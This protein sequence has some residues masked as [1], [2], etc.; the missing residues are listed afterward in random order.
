MEFLMEIKGLDLLMEYFIKS[1]LILTFALILLCLSRKKSSALKHFIL[2]LA[3]ISMLIIPLIS[4]LA[5]GWETKLLPSWEIGGRSL[6]L[7]LDR[8]NTNDT[9]I[10]GR[11]S[12][13]VS[14]QNNAYSPV[15]NEAGSFQ[16]KSLVSIL[17]ANQKLLS[18]G[19]AAI[20]CIGILFLLTRILLGLYGAYRLTRQGEKICYSNWRQLLQKLLQTIPI[21]RKISLL[22]HP[23]ILAPLTWG[24]RKPVVIFPAE[25]RGWTKCQCSSALFHE[26]SHIKRGDFLIKMIARISCALFWF[27]PLSWF[28]FKMMKQEQEK[29]CDELVLKAG[30]KPS[31][32][33]ANLLSLKNA[34]QTG[35][36]PPT[37]VLGAVGKSQ[38]NDRLIAIL[39]KQF[40]PKEIKMKTK[41]LLSLTVILVI[42]IIGFARPSPTEAYTKKHLS[43]S[44][45]PV[46]NNLA[47][48]PADDQEKQE[49]KKTT[50]TATETEI[51]KKI[52]ETQ[53]KKKEDK[54][55]IKKG[56][57][58]DIEVHIIQGDKI[59]K[60]GLEGKQITLIGQDGEKKV[61]TISMDKGDL[62]IADDKEGHWTLKADK[63]ELLHGDEVK[64]ITLK[65]GTAL[66]VAG[67]DAVKLDKGKFKVITKAGEHKTGSFY[68]HSGKGDKKIIYAT[69]H[70]KIYSTAHLDTHHEK[71]KEKIKKIREKLE[72]IKKAEDPHAQAETRGETITELEEMLKELEEI[73]QQKT[74]VISYSIHTEPKTKKEEN[75]EHIRF[76]KLDADNVV[77]NFAKEDKII[78]LKAEEDGI[79]VIFKSESDADQKARHEDLL[80]K[81][82]EKLP[83]HYNIE[84]ITDEDDDVFIIKIVNT[85]KDKEQ[86]EDI[87]QLL[88]EIIGEIKDIKAKDKK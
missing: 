52:S 50:K 47:F 63:L 38:L 14:S 85:K 5:T 68:I 77:I 3:L 46:K 58:G 18:T 25:S 82:K 60:L 59:K 56:E 74:G 62:I 10:S 45:I 66:W 44:L 6:A 75:F 30:V 53:E 24:I 27:N 23:R 35:W 7:S 65:D 41:I 70:A 9:L 83:Q 34:H 37:A 17:S 29:A 43:S 21:K 76:E 2:S 19:L 31:T 22:R 26:L 48:L 15:S 86:K 71:L 72:K 33:A 20:W 64:T 12:R 69:P 84:S 54:L 79:Q 81:L 67:K 87:Y 88:K 32:Y 61:F 40:N 13:S 42:L 39:K 4:S 51:A 73:V 1:T 36:N 11:L 55:V 78:A 49:K 57:K 8:S 28:T 80:K 16:K